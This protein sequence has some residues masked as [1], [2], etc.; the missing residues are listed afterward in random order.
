L[1][2]PYNRTDGT[3]GMGW[4]VHSGLTGEGFVTL[5]TS[6]SPVF[7]RCAVTALG[8][9]ERIDPS[10]PSRYLHLGYW[11]FYED[12]DSTD[13]GGPIGFYVSQYHFL[14]FERESWGDATSSNAQGYSG[15]FYRLWPGVQVTLGFFQP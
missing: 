9:A 14:N 8:V 15:F 6:T 3:D 1:T 11:A 12:I 7:E 4:E 2:Y 13:W 10:D 5:A